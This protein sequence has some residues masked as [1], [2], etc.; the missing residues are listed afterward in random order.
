MATIKE[1]FWVRVQNG[2]VTDCWDVRP[3]EEQLTNQAGWR[4]AV[5]VMPDVTPRRE[6]V[7]NHTFDVTKTPVEI[8]W[9][10]ASLTIED[11]RG[12]L[13]SNA[14]FN[15]RQIIEEQTRLEMSENPAEEFDTQVVIDA[16]A[17]FATRVA[18]LNAAVTH[19]DLDAL[20]E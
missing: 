1:G 10:K 6:Y 5:E 3:S 16:K 19:E 18:A 14:K 8:V 4:E 20:V 7:T 2:V 15:L 9:S 12:G 13:I 11:R 17:A